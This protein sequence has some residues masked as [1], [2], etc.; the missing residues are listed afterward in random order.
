MSNEIQIKLPNEHLIKFVEA[1]KEIN[2]DDNKFKMT[3]NNPRFNSKYLKLEDMIQVVEPVLLKH[4]FIS[5]FTQLTN[6]K[7]A[8]LFELRITYTPSMQYLST[9]VRLA[10]ELDP[11]RMGSLMTYAKRYLY[12][13]LLMFPFQEDDDGNAVSSRPEVRTK[14]GNSMYDWF[15]VIQ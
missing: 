15:Y 3:G 11:Q 13:N 2:S 4:N 7:D 10:K 8:S 12:G 5:Q 9:Y 6:E 14:V 1:R